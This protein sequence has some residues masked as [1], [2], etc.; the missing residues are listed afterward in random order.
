MGQ[1][2]ML[3]LVN[4]YGDEVEKKIDGDPEYKPSEGAELLYLLLDGIF[5]GKLQKKDIDKIFENQN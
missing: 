5:N 4:E 3:D 2:N 1:P